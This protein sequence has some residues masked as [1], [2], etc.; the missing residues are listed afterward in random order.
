MVSE[1]HR[2]QPSLRV[3]WV[4][5][6]REKG[7]K[8]CLVFSHQSLGGNRGRGMS[9]LWGPS[10]E[11][12]S[13]PT[14]EIGGGSGCRCPHLGWTS[15]SSQGQSFGVSHLVVVL[16]GS[17]W[18]GWQWIS[19]APPFLLLSLLSSGPHWSLYPLFLL[20]SL[21]CSSYVCFSLRSYLAL[22][23]CHSVSYLTL[24]A[25]FPL[26]LFLYKNNKQGSL[27]GKSR[28]IA[29][30][31]RTQMVQE[32]HLSWGSVGILLWS[33]LWK[34]P[35]LLMLVYGFRLTDI[36]HYRGKLTFTPGF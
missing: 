3:L 15:P 23:F 13:Y 1:V 8:W 11:L 36:Y 28:K 29:R 4:D 34:Y 35:N 16:G 20:S 30:V 9:T 19:V 17:G 22:S 26:L 7:R 6:K 10:M 5:G 27:G 31:G 18:A 25:P 21:S 12:R 24:P 2:G 14:L 32:P 33:V